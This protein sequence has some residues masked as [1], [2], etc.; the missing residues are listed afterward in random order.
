MFCG[1]KNYF[2]IRIIKT[3]PGYTS[4]RWLCFVRYV[5]REKMCAKHIALYN[6]LAL[7]HQQQHTRLHIFRNK[8]LRVNAC[9]TS[10]PPPSART[11]PEIYMALRLLCQWIYESLYSKILYFARSTRAPCRRSTVSI[12]SLNLFL[13]SLLFSLFFFSRWSR[14]SC[15]IICALY[16]KNIFFCFISRKC[17]ARS[18][19]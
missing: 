14:W 13:F 11:T 5:P 8:T 15:C 19:A 9:T 4:A 7:P 1:T 10:P 3:T 2:F 18:L 6:I 17:S 12:K 16:S